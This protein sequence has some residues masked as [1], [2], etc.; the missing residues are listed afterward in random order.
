M[1]FDFTV[2]E[3]I[4][5]S[6]TGT[7]P[8]QFYRR[9]WNLGGTGGSP[10]PTWQD[11]IL[12]GSTALT[13]V[14][15]KE[16]SLSYLKLFGGTEL[17]PETYLDT[18]TAE[19]KCIQSNVPEGY[20]QVGGV[21]NAS[22]GYINTGIIADVDDIE[23]DIVA[24]YNISSGSSWYVLQSR[25]SSGASIYGISGSQTGNTIV[26]AFSGTSTTV[27]IARQ[28][29]H[30]YHI[31]FKCKNGNAT[32]YV[33][34]LTDNTSETATG[35]YTFT[36]ATTNI[37]LF[38][39]I[40]GGGTLAN[41]NTDVLS[42]YIIKSGVKVMD[43]VSC[44]DSNSVAGYYDWASARFVGA[45]YGSMS[46]RSAVT[47]TPSPTTPVSL[48][49]NNGK[50]DY[51]M[52][53]QSVVA[54]GTPEVITD[55]DGNTATCENLVNV[56]VGTYKDTQEIFS[57]VVTRKS[58]I[59]VLDGT[60]DWEKKTVGGASRYQITIADARQSAYYNLFVTHGVSSNDTSGNTWGIRNGGLLTFYY[61]SQ[62]FPT[63]TDFTNWLTK[64]YNAGSP[65]MIIY[66]LE[67]S[68][69]ESVSPQGLSKSPVTVTGSISSLVVN[70]TESSHTTPNPYQPLDINCNNGVVKV[71]P[72][73][74]NKAT[75][76]TGHG[77]YISNNNNQIQDATSNGTIVLDCKPNT[78][79]SFW[80]TNGS[81]GCRAFTMNKDTI[82]VGDTGVWVTQS[83]A[84]TVLANTVCTTYATPSD[85]KKL[86]ILGYR[87]DVMNRTRE[88]Q[89]NDLMLV[90]GEVSTATPYMAYGTTYVDGTTETVKDSLNNTAT[91][92]NL[93]AVG[94][95]KDVQEVLTGAVTR[96]VGVY[97]F[98]GT[99]TLGIANATFTAQIR[100]KISSK[101]PLWCSHFEYSTKTSSQ[102]E[103]SKIISFASTNVG[104]RYDVCADTT[105]FKAWLKSQY[106]NE[107][108]V[109]VI[110]PLATA[111]TESVTPQS[112]NIQA[113]TNIIE[114]SQASIDGLELEAK[115]KAGVEVTV[116]E[117]EDAQL[118]NDVTVTIS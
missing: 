37:G 48:I 60:E 52:S 108:P 71:S 14:N 42:A 114:I 113:G 45:T 24:Q 10:S 78:K 49:C 18:V 47:P 101:T 102:V 96:N 26:G 110:Y 75:D 89:L 81:G 23:F 15:S 100:D 19:G 38:S 30:I 13:L 39:N 56:G 67:T 2:K 97:V 25:A 87:S 41:G 61:D 4:I 17:L 104:F 5:G 33:E 55:S 36:A 29:N 86:Y 98:D 8:L 54:L 83:T 12:K 103:D 7:P 9:G 28:L 105:A 40:G 70:T 106:E 72:N 65:V 62:L 44:T 77:W 82:A 51:N 90:E 64:Q 57:G 21:T 117:I 116:E 107:T 11:I 79:Y 73:R 63:V 53:I 22:S 3:F 74:F 84:T 99:E 69:T 6:G 35:T 59:L 76:D 95:Y 111:T 46:A 118:S 94:T 91:A 27:S 68:T 43:Y 1:T 115:Y 32:L 31:N 50:L 58:K 34:D 85:A 109:I 66:P 92:L 88:D 93:F 16:D 80:H 20:T 112:L